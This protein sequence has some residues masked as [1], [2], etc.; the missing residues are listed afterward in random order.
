MDARRAGVA[1]VLVSAAVVAFESVAVEGALNIANIDLFLVSAVP[2]IMGGLILLGIRPRE[3][4]GF[5]NS[6]GL[7]GWAKM[8]VLGALVGVG[9]LLWF[10]AVRRIG[11]SKEAILGGGSSE[12]LFVVLLSAL[13]LRERL[14][15]LEAVGSVL[16]LGGVFIV[17][18]NTSEVTLTIGPG[19][20]EAV[21][22]S[23]VLGSSVVYTTHLLRD[24]DLTPLSGLELLLSGVVV[25]A[26]GTAAGIIRLPGDSWGWI[27][28]VLIG[29]FPAIGL[30]TYNSGLPRVGASLTSVLFAL[31]GIMTV[32]VQL[33]V[34]AFAPNANIMLPQSVPL[35]VL[36]GVVAFAGVY[37][38][39]RRPTNNRKGAE[40]EI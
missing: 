40:G 13:F 28:L 26:V 19:E 15:Q 5:V 39:N 8:L 33:A 29:L 24:Y 17:L 22:S 18:T 3:T 6:L 20:I 34:L 38:L 2:P 10:D 7:S 16:V 21:A 12:V 31:N 27:I 4:R 1:I 32:G 9:V 14:K 35:A 36:G 30:G 11:A 23:L 25:L 37:L